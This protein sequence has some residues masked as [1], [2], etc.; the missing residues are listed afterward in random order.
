VNTFARFLAD[1]EA[2]GIPPDAEA[3]VIR[4]LKRYQGERIYIG[5]GAFRHEKVERACR[6]MASGKT[7]AEAAQELIVTQGCCLRTAYGLT[8]EAMDSARKGGL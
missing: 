2:L 4:L 5:H 6:L 3:A 7:R 8:N 1:L